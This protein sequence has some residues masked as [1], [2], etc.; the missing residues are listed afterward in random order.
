M[1]VTTGS[2]YVFMHNFFLG[3]LPDFDNF[4]VEVQL[5]TGQRV[6]GIDRYLIGSNFRNRYN[7]ALIGLKLH[8]HLHG[9]TAECAFGNVLNHLRVADAVAFFGRNLNL[10]FIAG[11]FTVQTVFHAR[12]EVALTV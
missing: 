6:V 3:C 1:V 11:R 7:L 5:L 2:V 4:H 12:D 9:L 10:E 8:T